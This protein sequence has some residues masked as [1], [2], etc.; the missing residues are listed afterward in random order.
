MIWSGAEAVMLALGSDCR[1]RFISKEVNSRDHNKS[2]VCRLIKTLS[3]SEWQV[4]TKL[5]LVAGSKSESNTYFSPCVVHP[6]FYIPLPSISFS[7]THTCLTQFW[8]TH[9]FSP[10]W[11]KNKCCWRASLKRGKDPMM[12]QQKTL[13]LPTKRKLHFKENTKSPT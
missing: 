13:R 4:T 8:E 2:I 11:M 10:K 7:H 5:H 1:C 3:M 9:N 12:R 6:L